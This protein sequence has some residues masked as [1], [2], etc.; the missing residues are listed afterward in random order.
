MIDLL[1]TNNVIYLDLLTL[2]LKVDELMNFFKA[3]DKKAKIAL[4]VVKKVY[5]KFPK[6]QIFINKK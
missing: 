5:D 2:K 1:T 6:T 4:A 3:M